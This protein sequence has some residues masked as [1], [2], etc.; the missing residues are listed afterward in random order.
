MLVLSQRS[1]AHPTMKRVA[2]DAR[3]SEG[4]SLSFIVLNIRNVFDSEGGRDPVVLTLLKSSNSSLGTAIGNIN[5]EL[6]ESFRFL[7]NKEDSLHSKIVSPTIPPPKSPRIPPDSAISIRTIGTALRLLCDKI[8]GDYEGLIGD[9]LYKDECERKLRQV[10]ARRA[11]VS[12]L[13]GKYDSYR[14]LKSRNDVAIEALEGQ[15]PRIRTSN[16]VI[17]VLDKKAASGRVSDAVAALNFAIEDSAWAKSARVAAAPQPPPPPSLSTPSADLFARGVRIFSSLPSRL[18]SSVSSALAVAASS[19][20]AAASSS[21]SATEPDDLR[22][23]VSRCVDILDRSLNALEAA[24]YTIIM[25]VVSLFLVRGE[26][27]EFRRLFRGITDVVGHSRDHL[28]L[29]NPTPTFA[30]ELEAIIDTTDGGDDE[31]DVDDLG[32]G[33]AVLATTFAAQ[34]QV[35][36]LVGDVES[37]RLEGFLKS[38]KN[39]LRMLEKTAKDQPLPDPAD[40]RI[41]ES[42]YDA[43]KA[44]WS[45]VNHECKERG[46]PFQVPE[47]YKRPAPP[48]A[49][50]DDDEDGDESFDYLGR[51]PAGH[52]H[53]RRGETVGM[54]V[55][56][57]GCD[58]EQPLSRFTLSGAD[59]NTSSSGRRFCINTPTGRRGR[60]PTQRHA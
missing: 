26:H 12:S 4:E 13:V 55:D 18:V 44:L 34:R 17:S 14:L 41:L 50:R 20:A 5:R 37:S 49:E 47:R 16:A 2:A 32:R 43:L 3:P 40:F 35:A 30:D 36:S 9:A 23:C 54:L 39:A 6:T 57:D 15:R 56:D 22:L 33:V 42:R 28:P 24:R 11:M 58:F 52:S 38:Y 31:D 19:T 1:T 60:R 27:R 51:G 29:L 7:W 45:S 8:I 48:P 53:T 46:I 10:A 21:T 59:G 25:R